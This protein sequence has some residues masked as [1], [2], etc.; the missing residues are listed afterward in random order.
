METSHNI[1]DENLS[2]DTYLFPTKIDIILTYAIVKGMKSGK[3]E[4]AVLSGS[5]LDLNLSRF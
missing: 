3:N 2:R 4:M 1:P 5:N